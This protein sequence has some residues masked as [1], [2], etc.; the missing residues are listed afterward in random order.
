[1][2]RGTWCA[3]VHGVAE[4]SDTTEK[5]NN[6]TKYSQ[7]VYRTHSPFW[8]LFFSTGRSWGNTTLPIKSRVEEKRASEVQ[9]K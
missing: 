4:K 1:M 7:N 8:Y 3:T 2:D 6:T 5:L 9:E